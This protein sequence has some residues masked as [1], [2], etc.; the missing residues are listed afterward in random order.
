MKAVIN[1]QDTQ[2]LSMKYFP[3]NI[4]NPGEFG[5]SFFNRIPIVFFKGGTC[6]FTRKITIG[7][8]QAGS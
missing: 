5:V 4:R 2:T 1:A 3:G 7:Y 8:M 6:Y